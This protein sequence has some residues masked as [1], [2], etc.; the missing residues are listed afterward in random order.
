M[1]L[2]RTLTAIVLIAGVVYIASCTVIDGC[3]VRGFKKDSAYLNGVFEPLDTSWIT[4]GTLW[5]HAKMSRVRVKQRINITNRFT[6]TSL[7]SLRKNRIWRDQRV[8]L[9]RW[10]ENDAD[11]QVLWENKSMQTQSR[12]FSVHCTH[13]AQFCEVQIGCR[14]F[15]RVGD[16]FPLSKYLHSQFVEDLTRKPITCLVIA[17][18]VGIFLHLRFSETHFTNVSISYARVVE[19]GE[20]WRIF[21]ASVSHYDLWHI[22]FNVSTAYSIGSL[23]AKLG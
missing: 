3:F 8:T 1:R 18:L 13:R 15:P 14:A 12:T 17:G 23:E 2:L 22:L 19:H 16:V 20:V 11:F 9:R 4:R 21:T 10:S 7:L 6:L 5:S